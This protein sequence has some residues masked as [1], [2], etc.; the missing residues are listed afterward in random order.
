[1]R[2]T[3]RSKRRGN[4]GGS[5]RT[6]SVA[7]HVC[8][9]L[10][11]AGFSMEIS[12]KWE[13]VVVCAKDTLLQT[14][15]QQAGDPGMEIR[16]LSDRQT[17]ESGTEE[18]S[19]KEKEDIRNAFISEFDFQEIEE[20]LGRIFPEEKIS[21]REVT[22]ALISGEVEEAWDLLRQY[23][24]DVLW[25]EFR[26][27][28]HHL[29]YILAVSVIAAIFSNFSGVFQ[30]RQISEI[31]FYILYMLLITI[32]LTAFG[33]AIQG[34]E[35]RMEMLTDFMGV[36]CPLF[37]LAVSL[38]TGAV[39]STFFY[40]VT[41]FLIYLVELVIVRLLIPVIHVYLMVRVLGSLTGEDFLSELAQLLQK[42][43]IWVLRSLLACVVGVNV[44]Q[45]LL[46]PAIDSLKRGTITNALGAIPWVGNAVG[47]TAELLAGTAV[48]IKNGIGMAGA[49]TAVV[50]CAL[51]VLQML[52]LAF[53]YKLAAAAVQPVSD[54]RITACI[55]GVS[56]GYELLVKV[57][58]TSAI[59]FLLT[60]AVTAVFTQ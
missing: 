15:D 22:S 55:S 35:E 11:L 53:L 9:F 42:I 51:P 28:W 60:I 27:N 32:C 4:Q 10:C 43:V 19:D 2:A 58:S 20:T 56:E 47:G 54:K 38:S 39:S 25:Y 45:G 24:S 7:I 30:N 34:V 26:T 48:L 8:I 59:L 1:M 16:R 46:G 18:D 57:V 21:F 14:S 13:P 6:Q 37:F 5:R 49:V 3:L 17:V 52:L 36:F 12:A 44:M 50:I 41:L 33:T 23:V 29:V 40:H 31:S